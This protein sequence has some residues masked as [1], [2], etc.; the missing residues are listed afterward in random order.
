MDKITRG[1][2]KPLH[3]C[4][5]F[6][7]QETV[8][9]F[10]YMQQ[11][12]H[13]GKI[14]VSYAESGVIQVPV[15]HLHPFAFLFAPAYM[16]SFQVRP[17]APRPSLR[18]DVSYLIV[19]GLRGV[20]GS[21][22]LYMARHG[23]R[24]LVVMAR[25]DFTDATS[26][27][28]MH[29]LAALDCHITPISGDVTCLSSVRAAVKNAPRPIVGVIHG[30]MVLR[31]GLFS[32][33]TPSSF[34]AP[35][36]PKVA[37]TWNLHTVS[38]EQDTP[39]DF[40]TMLTSVS[41]LVGHISQSN[42]AAACVFQDSFASYRRQLGLRAC[43]V[44]LGV[45][46]DVGYLVEHNLMP[47]LEAQGWTPIGEALLHRIL[48]VSIL[49]QQRQH[50]QDQDS[51][52]P[53]V[54]SLCQLITGLPVPIVPPRNPL[55]PVHRFSA[56]AV[57]A[58][59]DSQ[60]QHA[61]NPAADGVDLKLAILKRYRASSSPK[62]SSSSLDRGVVLAAAVDVVN[63][64]LARSLGAAEPLEPQRPLASYGIDSL[65]AV[66]LR[67]WARRELG[68]EVSGVEVVGAKTLLALCEGMVEKMGAL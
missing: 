61:Q 66:E 64:V 60:T 35:I 6:P 38:L 29:S 12:K 67:N 16:M 27:S 14:V 58:T 40:F 19:G 31:D 7:F 8:D 49:Q 18:P 56:L 36:S 54:D 43:A 55:D 9:A 25:S 26:Q 44:D 59:R 4:R 1:H 33:M 11:G 5:V 13:F 23:A 3:I 46:G 10:R 48:A 57:S 51:S 32:S 68:I 24:N 21:L 28:V 2:L 39:L 50:L 63:A 42:Y 30:A 53:V 45:V 47:R 34:L 62:D 41:G 22:A 15:R 52:R 65:V 17:I 37:G 20:C